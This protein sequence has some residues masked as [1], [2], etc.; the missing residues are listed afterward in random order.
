MFFATLQMLFR[1]SSEKSW[2]RVLRAISVLLACVVGRKVS[3]LPGR[4]V[5]V[6]SCEPSFAPQWRHVAGKLQK[7]RGEQFFSIARRE[8]KLK[9]AGGEKSYFFMTDA[10]DSKKCHWNVAEGAVPGC[11]KS[12]YFVAGMSL[13]CRWARKQKNPGLIRRDIT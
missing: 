13:R 10:E 11:A 2:I 5:F 8:I 9:R 7:R 4:Q 3:R 6:L 1:S 12:G